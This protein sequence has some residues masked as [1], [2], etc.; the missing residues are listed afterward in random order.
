MSNN[1][2]GNIFNNDTFLDG[3]YLNCVPDAD[4]NKSPVL[5]YEAN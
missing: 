2:N 4:N 5:T 3:Y 1:K